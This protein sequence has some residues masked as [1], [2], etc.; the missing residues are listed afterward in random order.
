M[1]KSLGITTLL[2]CVLLTGCLI[3]CNGGEKTP[4]VEKSISIAEIPNFVVGESVDFKQFVTCEGGNESFYVTFEEDFAS[5]TD[6]SRQSISAS[7]SGE[8]KFTVHFGDLTKEGTVNIVSQEYVDFAE[9]TKDIGYKYTAYMLDQNWQYLETYYNYAENF[10]IEW[11]EGVGYVEIDGQVYQFALTEDE[12]NPI[13]YQL[14]GYEPESLSEYSLPFMFNI[15]DI[16]CVYVPEEVVSGKTYPAYESLVCDN[17]ESVEKFVEGVFG[18]SLDLLA[19]YDYY[20]TRV[21]FETDYLIDD[22]RNKNPVWDAY[23]FINYINE[24]TGEFE[25][26]LFDLVIFDFSEESYAAPELAE[27]FAESKPAG[28]DIS[29]LIS[30]IDAALGEHNFTVTYSA[31]WFAVN[32]RGQRTAL[33]SNPFVYEG[34]EGLGSMINHYLNKIGSIKA[35]VTPTQTYVENE[36]AAH[37]YGLVSKDGVYIYEGENHDAFKVSEASS[38]FDEE[39]RGEKANYAFMTTGESE[40]SVLASAFVNSYS[41][42]KN[43]YS[44]SFCAA[45]AEGLFQSLFMEALPTPEVIDEEIEDDLEYL[46]QYNNFYHTA[47]LILNGGSIPLDRYLTVEGKATVDANGK[48][49]ELSLSFVWEDESETGAEVDYIMSVTFSNFGI[50]K[51]PN[52]VVVNY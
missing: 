25:E 45:S 20:P 26:G 21:E 19:Q 36:D 4:A 40:D 31:D 27:Y 35:Y 42:S 47:D 50:T 48:L 41:F 23:L 34:A 15:E 5:Y 8:V 22:A 13:E 43:V 17:Q 6:A 2:S 3:G 14:T 12:E 28:K 38:I 44:F 51:I 46:A 9:A 32:S 24:E 30:I 33:G 7:H 10:F 37:S 16:K 18:Y 39:L 29:D 49:T 11:F 1:K 52:G